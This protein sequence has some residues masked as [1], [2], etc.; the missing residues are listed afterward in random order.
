MKD[1]LLCLFM[2]EL[3]AIRAMESF[4]DRW[5]EKHNYCYLDRIQEN[6]WEGTPPCETGVRTAFLANTAQPTSRLNSRLTYPRFHLVPFSTALSL[7]WRLLVVRVVSF[8][9]LRNNNALR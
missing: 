1:S 2:R 7:V 5:K 3:Q 6:V 8:P 4:L 9:R